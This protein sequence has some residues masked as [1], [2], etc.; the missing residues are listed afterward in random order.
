M[1]NNSPMTNGSMASQHPQNAAPG[2]PRLRLPLWVGVLL[3]LPAMAGIAGMAAMPAMQGPRFTAE[4]GEITLIDRIA[5]TVN[6][7]VI[8]Q[9]EIA[10]LKNLQTKEF[11]SRYKGD[12][13]EKKLRGMKETLTNQMI[14]DMLLESHAEALNI[15][16]SDRAIEDRLDTILRRDSAMGTIYTQAQLKSFILKEMLRRNVLNREVNSRVRVSDADIRQECDKQGSTSREVEVGHILIRDTED[17][18]RE[19]LLAIRAELEQG[20][21]FETL[22]VSRSQD[23]S[24]ASNRGR[25]GFIGRGQFVKPFEEKAFNMRVGELSGPVRTKFGLHLIKVFSERTRGKLDCS[26]LDDVTRQT[27][28][29][30]V[31]NTHRSARLKE[32]FVRLRRKAT[33]RILN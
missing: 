6:E 30:R 14:D 26:K 12:E 1:K 20:A 7:K 32:F 13:L 10:E 31:Y 22:A 21:D 33:I 17:N 8:T 25:L 3:A 9:R 4:A 24:A 23:P 2:N 18:A 27:F 11:E 15:E 29:A 28:Y 16:I 5:I 19:K